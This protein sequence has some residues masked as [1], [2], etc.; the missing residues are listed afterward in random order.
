MSDKL[1]VLIIGTG[2]VAAEH[3]KAYMKNPHTEIRGLCDIVEDRA[4]S[5]G[6]KFGI[7]CPV[8]GDYK[9]LLSGDDIDTVSICSI[10][11]AHFE[12][13]KAAIEAGK[14]VLVEKPLCFTFEQACEL[15]K[16][17]LER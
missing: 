3:I 15:R 12:Q 17:T 4:R 7:D 13:A 16:L 9:K 1:G 11:S 8:G 6:D 14:H 5:V 10:N 2:W